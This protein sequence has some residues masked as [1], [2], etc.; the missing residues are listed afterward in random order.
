MYSMFYTL[1]VLVPSLRTL[2]PITFTPFFIV[3]TFLSFRTSAM[4]TLLTLTN[5]YFVPLVLFNPLLLFPFPLRHLPL[6]SLPPLSLKPL[7][8]WLPMM[9]T[10]NMKPSFL[11]PPKPLKP[12]IFPMV[13]PSFLP[14]HRFSLNPNKSISPLPPW[15][16]LASNVFTTVTIERTVRNTAAPIA[17]SSPLVTLL[18]N[19]LLFNV[20]SVTTGDITANIVPIET[21][22]FAL[23]Q[24]TLW[25]TV[26]L[27]VFLHPSHLPFMVDPHLPPSSLWPERGLFIKPGV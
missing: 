20:I 7:L 3:F 9:T 14:L 17:T 22:E 1:M 10:T 21:V 15:I 12:S 13:P 8:L 2:N 26:L 11:S 18:D 23:H 27:S 16:P 24:D 19:V 6:E 5:F 25:V 4:H